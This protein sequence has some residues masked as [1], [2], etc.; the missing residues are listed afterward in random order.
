LFVRE[1]DFVRYD[2]I[3][4]EIMA[5]EEPKQLFGQIED[6]RNSIELLAR[7]TKARKGVFDAT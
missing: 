5:L 1:G 3:F 6:D 2:G 7:C 4:Y